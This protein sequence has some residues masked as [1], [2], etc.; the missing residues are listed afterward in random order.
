MAEPIKIGILR[1]AFMSTGHDVGGNTLNLLVE[2]ANAAGGVQG[3]PILPVIR[4]LDARTM[5][6]PENVE[7]AI[8]AWD[9]L[10][11]GEQVI[12]LIGPCTTP[13]ALAVHS[14][15]ESVGIPALHWAGTDRARGDWHFQ[16]QAGYLP[17]EG[18]ALVYVL[19][20]RRQRRVV[21]VRS[22]GEYGE[23]YLQPFLRAARGTGIEIA[24]EVVV[25]LGT[26]DLAEAVRAA[27]QTRPEALVAMGLFG[28]GPRLAAEIKR[29]DWAVP[30]YGN[31][32]FALMAAGSRQAR[33]VLEGWTTTNLYDRN[34]GVAA[35][36]LDRYEA[37]YGVR[38][39]TASACFAHDLVTL[40]VEGL[41]HAPDLTRGGLRRGLE[42]LRD[43]PSATGG[44]GT[45]MGFG[46]HDRLALKGPRIFTLTQIGARE[47]GE[48]APPRRP[49][50]AAG[51][52]P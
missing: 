43:M 32:G 37:R 9:E 38:P 8:A 20:Q 51:H 19:A 27:R 15:V 5:G 33:E 10:V 24:G 29:Q 1:D 47:E 11:E 34:N 6:T 17:D 7:A 40:M 49:A 30:C 23:D 31:C 39:E 42:E 18:P 26:E 3:R 48:P 16:F 12:G 44:A 2:E 25:P 4:A 36:F 21:C 28:L 45:R 14:R 13:V 50:Y 22:E 46:P 41:R 35:A 52:L